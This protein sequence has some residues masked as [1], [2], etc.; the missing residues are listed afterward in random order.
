M[1]ENRTQIVMIRQQK[2]IMSDFIQYLTVL[3]SLVWVL[4]SHHQYEAT[5]Y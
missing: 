4:F 5:I 3:V 2:N 1:L